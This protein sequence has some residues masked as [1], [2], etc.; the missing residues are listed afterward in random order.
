MRLHRYE[1]S[2]PGDPKGDLPKPLYDA[3]TNGNGLSIRYINADGQA[4]ARV[5]RPETSFTSGRYTYIRAF[6]EKSGEVSTFRLDRIVLS[7][8]E[9]QLN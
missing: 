8:E 5:I 4:S 9:R 3:L 2:W 6:C 1:R 7:G